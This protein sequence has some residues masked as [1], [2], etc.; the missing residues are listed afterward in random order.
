MLLRLVTG[1]FV[2]CRPLWSLLIKLKSNLLG[3]QHRSVARTRVNLALI[4]SVRQSIEAAKREYELALPVLE[5]ASAKDAFYLAKCLKGLG[6]VKASQG[7]PLQAL[8]FYTRALA[9]MPQSNAAVPHWA[10]LHY[11]YAEVLVALG[12]HDEALEA[13][14]DMG[15]QLDRLPANREVYIAN[16][17]NLLGTLY[18]EM[19]HFGHA[20]EAFRKGH[21]FMSKSPLL[22]S[23]ATTLLNINM[24]TLCHCQK[25]YDEAQQWYEESLK[26]FQNIQ[27]PL[28]K[29]VTV[30]HFNLGINHIEC[31][32][33]DEGAAFLD[34]ALAESGQKGTEW[35]TIKIRVLH[36]RAKL[37]NLRKDFKQAVALAREAIALQKELTGDKHPLL[38]PMHTTQGNLLRDAGQLE[39]AQAAFQA[40]HAIQEHT[41][42]P[43]HP[44]RAETLEGHAKLFRLMHRE[45]EALQAEA[46]AKAIREAPD[47]GPDRSLEEV[48]GF[49]PKALSAQTTYGFSTIFMGLAILLG[50]LHIDDALDAFQQG[51]PFFS[52]G[53]AGMKVF[54]FILLFSAI[55]LLMRPVKRTKTIMVLGLLIASLGLAFLTYFIQLSEQAQF[56]RFDTFVLPLVL[57]LGQIGFGMHL[58][59]AGFKRLKAPERKPQGP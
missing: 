19:A 47:P 26:L 54:Y 40:A 18:L 41:L 48:I 24:G 42:R 21:A 7:K 50:S 8:P 25:R 43:Q 22:S 46:S 28:R 3:A 29:L 58:A 10:P 37:L 49:E 45:Q 36:A 30:L 55:I 52:L 11:E 14:A 12:R 35:A 53:M 1:A 23:Y 17:F 34:K 15:H 5:T 6:S 51:T 57:H 38:G 31:K 33:L 44:W 9:T 4:H 13:L 16:A 39:E 2:L 27:G 20:E 56:R 59:L 32:R